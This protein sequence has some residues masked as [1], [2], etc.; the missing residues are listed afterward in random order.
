MPGT[1]SRFSR[2]LSECSHGRACTG[3]RRRPARLPRRTSDATPTTPSPRGS[4]ASAFVSSGCCRRAGVPG[5]AS[6]ARSRPR[7]PRVPSFASQQRDE[8]APRPARG[9]CNKR[10]ASLISL[11]AGAPRRQPFPRSQRRTDAAWTQDT[12]HTRNCLCRSRCNDGQRVLS[13]RRLLAQWAGF[14]SSRVMAGASK[15]R[16]RTQSPTDSSL[17][18]APPYILHHARLDDVTDDF[19]AAARR[20]VALERQRRRQCDSCGRRHHRAHVICG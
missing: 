9:R 4:T 20:R 15:A 1:S 13:V 10:A 11:I 19:R 17:T 3:V 18:N 7:S 2:W 12:H 8:G 6:S 5:G 16:G 14:H